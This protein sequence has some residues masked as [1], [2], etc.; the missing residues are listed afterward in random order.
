MATRV[1]DGAIRASRV[2]RRSRARALLSLNLKKKRDWSQSTSLR[3]KRF[4]S[5]YSAKVI[6]GAKKMEGGGGGEKRERLP[7]SPTILENAPLDR[8]QKPLIG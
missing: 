5:S 8:A 6:A 3:S 4:Q 7:A 1:T 2:L